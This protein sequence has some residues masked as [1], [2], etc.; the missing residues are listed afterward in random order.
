MLRLACLTGAN[1]PRSSFNKWRACILR[2]GTTAVGP[3]LRTTLDGDD[4]M[5]SLTGTEGV[6]RSYW[7]PIPAPSVPSKFHL[8][9]TAASLYFAR[10]SE[11][12]H[13]EYTH[14]K[15]IVHD[16][17]TNWSTA[18][19][20]E[21]GLTLLGL[22]AT[23]RGVL[24]K[25]RVVRFSP[26]ESGVLPNHRF[27][28]GDTVKISSSFSNGQRRQ[29]NNNGPLNSGLD[30]VVLERRAW[31]VD[32]CIDHNLYESHDWSGFFRLDS[33]VNK[34]SYERMADGLQQLTSSLM[35]EKNDIDVDPYD[36]LY[37]PCPWL[38]DLVVL[39]YPDSI[40]RLSGSAGGLRM[41]LPALHGAAGDVQSHRQGA[42]APIL[43]CSPKLSELA[44]GNPSGKGRL[45]PVASCTSQLSLH[46]F[47]VR[48]QGRK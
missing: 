48:E 47:T 2:C 39:S 40:L 3:S 29:L 12:L 8:K 41:A 34:T 44:G 15:Q 10:S 33:H 26:D 37:L 16:R 22:C 36:K 46:V 28:V 38:R 19:L 25:D 5:P 27:N 35:R 9:R 1:A 4:L 11:I 21:E 18:M 17:L 45:A 42:N 31:Y 43:T 14:E 7:G 23:P 30:G 32:V 20:V 24:F 6:I 13:A